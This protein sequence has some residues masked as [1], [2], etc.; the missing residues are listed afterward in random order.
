MDTDILPIDLVM[1]ID[2]QVLDTNDKLEEK[3]SEFFVVIF[4]DVDLMKFQWT[5][6]ILYRDICHGYGVSRPS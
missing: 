5:S 1:K 4:H 2:A 3:M 6:E